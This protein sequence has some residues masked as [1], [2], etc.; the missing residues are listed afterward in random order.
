MK[1]KIFQTSTKCFDGES[2]STV[3]VW[4]GWKCPQSYDR[5]VK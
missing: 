3:F 4:K 1:N 2:E 5:K